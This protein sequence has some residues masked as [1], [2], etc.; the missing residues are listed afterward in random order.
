MDGLLTPADVALLL[1][2]S[3]RSAYDLLSSGAFPVLRVT[4]GT[5]RPAIRVDARDLQLWIDR[6]RAE[7]QAD[8]D[9][10]HADAQLITDIREAGRKARA[11]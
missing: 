3:R 11:G 9:K 5:K 10:A 4:L 2:I 7:Q 8:I 6:Q 1:G